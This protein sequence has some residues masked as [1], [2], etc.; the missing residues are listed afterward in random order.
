M[1]LSSYMTVLLRVLLMNIYTW[2]WEVMTE[3]KEDSAVAIS[4]SLNL[5]R[6]SLSVVCLSILCFLGVWLIK[7][8]CLINISST[9]V[10]MELLIR[11][12]FWPWIFL[13]PVSIQW[14]LICTSWPELQSEFDI[15]L[16][17][18]PLIYRFQEMISFRQFVWF[19]VH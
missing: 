18:V 1:H 14:F 10:I 8:D 5:F 3:D 13:M 11:T 7:E 19:T 9:W 17:R 15:S 16:L 6:T 2:I 4:V 12:H